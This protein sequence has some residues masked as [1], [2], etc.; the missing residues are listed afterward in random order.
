MTSGQIIPGKVIFANKQNRPEGIVTVSF[1]G[2]SLARI[3]EGSRLYSETATLFQLPNTLHEGHS[4]PGEYEWPFDFIFPSGTSGEEK[5]WSAISPYKASEGHQL[6]PSV[7]FD[8]VQV[9][10]A[11]E[12]SVSYKIEAKFSK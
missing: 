10:A 9:L 7:T 8:S 1:V 5:A 4:S 2:R 6:P 12:G 11:G 3:K